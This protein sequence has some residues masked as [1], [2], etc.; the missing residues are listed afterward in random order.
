VSEREE[1]R[2]A[3]TWDCEGV[4]VHLVVAHRERERQRELVE[5]VHDTGQVGQWVQPS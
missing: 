1:K 3:D 5:Q 4:G 2:A